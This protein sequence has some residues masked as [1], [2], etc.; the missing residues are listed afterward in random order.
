MSARD[1]GELPAAR[2]LGVLLVLGGYP[3]V[4]GEL[5]HSRGSL[6]S[7]VAV[8]LVV[9]L[10]ENPEQRP[11][12]LRGEAGRFVGQDH[13]DGVPSC[14]RAPFRAA[15]PDLGLLSYGRVLLICEPLSRHFSFRAAR[16]C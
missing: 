4:E 2:R 6:R 9:G 12:C 10:E 13:A 16:H 5:D 11:C 14:W 15:R 1:A 8:E 7:S 3:A